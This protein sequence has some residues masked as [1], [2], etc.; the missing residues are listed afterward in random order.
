MASPPS[1]STGIARTGSRSGNPA[2]EVI[3]L[4]ARIATGDVDATSIN[5][6]S[7]PEPPGGLKAWLDVL[8]TLLIFISAWGLTQTFGIFQEIYRTSL[9]PTSSAS[10]ISWIG[11]VQTF[12]VIVLGVI[13]GPLFDAGHLRPLLVVG[14]LLIGFGMSMLSL[15][16]TYWQVFL[17]QA[18]CVGLGSGLVYVPSLALVSTR[19]PP[20][21][22]PWAIGCVNSGGSVG[23]IIFTYMLRGLV[24]NIGFA[25]TV[26]AIALVNLVL[27]AVALAIILPSEPP[28]GTR[29][30]SLL[31]VSALRD[32]SFL[33]FAL[34]LLFDYIAFYIPPFYIPVYATVAL[35]KSREFAF[36]C[37]A[38]VSAGS[39][40]GRTVPMLAAARLGSLQVYLAASVAAV[41]L[42]F[43]W[44]AVRDSAGFVVFCVLYGLLSGVLV[45]A[46][47][48]AISHPVLSPSM[49]VIGTR[50]GMSWMFAGVG[51]LIGAPIAGALVDLRRA[52][53][54]PAQG[55][56]GGMVA[57][58]N[59]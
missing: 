17:A 41:V 24:P 45:A 35:G 44:M 18:L 25:W 23:G 9:L 11:S 1:S 38:F 26:R 46:P 8:A 49:G 15:A 16:S 30:R 37:V 6:V 47:S 3:E 28:R 22:R 12:L 42:L 19:F 7:V 51:V 54:S 40:F 58:G 53:F 43:A 50:M 52:D 55:F 14:C 32:P 34:A 27:A 20:C 56:A 31:D 13:T 21:T 57:K 2:E 39:F 48:A 29:R 36:D 10:S 5:A 59:P 33:L 4:D